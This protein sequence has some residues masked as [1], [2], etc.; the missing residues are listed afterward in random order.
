MCGEGVWEGRRGSGGMEKGPMGM[1][2]EK[3]GEK[4]ET[5]AEREINDMVEGKCK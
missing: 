3:K 1:D 5:M 4:R 2:R